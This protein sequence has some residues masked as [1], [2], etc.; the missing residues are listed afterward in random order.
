MNQVINTIIS[1]LRHKGGGASDRLDRR[2]WIAEE[3]DPLDDLKPPSK[4]MPSIH[5]QD[6][7]DT[8]RCTG[9]SAG[10]V[11]S[12]MLRIKHKKS[13]TV[14]GN[15]VWDAQLELG[16]AKEDRG[17]FI[18]SAPK[19]I[20]KYHVKVKTSGAMID[21][22]KG[23]MRVRKSRTEWKK[24]I[25]N[26]QPIMTGAIVGWPMVNPFSNYFRRV[27]KGSGH[28]FC[29]IGYDDDL[30]CFIGL[31]S[32]KGWGFKG[33]QTFFIRYEDLPALFTGYVF[34]K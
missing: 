29:I 2:D 12:I 24:R 8:N 17:D 34:L 13:V 21:K 15:D 6:Q 32:W 22:P 11:R 30:K 7:E 23:Y 27:K 18:H 28:A 33:E 26:G 4:F 31:N 16:T 25:A 20:C 9:F 1:E 14:E 19:A 5:P 10:H 3:I